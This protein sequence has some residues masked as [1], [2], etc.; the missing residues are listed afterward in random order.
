MDHGGGTLDEAIKRADRRKGKDRVIFRSRLSGDIGVRRG[1]KRRLEVTDPI[2][3]VGPGRDRLALKGPRNGSVL[4]FEGN[5]R[6]I[7]RNLKLKGVSIEADGYGIGL[8]IINAKLNGKGIEDAGVQIDGEN[9]Q[10][11]RLDVS[12]TRVSGFRQG[13]RVSRARARIDRSLISRNRG[14]GGVRIFNGVLDITKS[15]VA[16]NTISADHPAGAAGGGVAAVDGG[17]TTIKNSTISGNSA[18]GPGSRGGGVYGSFGL[19]GSTVTANSAENGGGLF[20][21]VP[22]QTVRNSIVAGN[23]AATDPDCGNGLKSNRDNVFGP[24][25]CGFLKPGDIRTARPGLSDLADH[26]GPT[27]TIALRKGS[28]AIDNAPTLGLR[29]DQRGVRRDRHPDSGAFERVRSFR[30][31][32]E[33]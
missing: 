7:V 15:T 4:R 23:T 5:G 11:G 29:R 6:S 18:S 16:G 12:R 20:G 19:D 32:Y 8:K 33:S 17:F 13:I 14:R 1:M 22:N 24:E 3:I 25:G 2:K 30:R 31:G 28:P 21:S 9:N 10:D 26:G 27:P